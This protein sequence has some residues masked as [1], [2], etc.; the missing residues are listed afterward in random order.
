MSSS[1]E[2]FSI[3]L[4]ISHLADTS[5]KKVH[6]TRL[7]LC[8]V[9]LALFTDCSHSRCPAGHVPND[10]R[11]ACLAP[12]ECDGGTLSDSGTCVATQATTAHDGGAAGE[13]DGGGQ[14]PGPAGSGSGG[15]SGETAGRD[16]GDGAGGREGG[17][18]GNAGSDTSAPPAAPRCG[19]GKVDPDEACDGN[20]KSSCPPTVGCV[21]SKLEGAASTCDAECV[22]TMISTVQDGDGCCP[23]GA[24]SGTDKDCP[25]SC[26]D[27]DLAPDEKCEPGSTD[28]PCP[29]VKD[30]DDGDPCT[31]DIVTGTAEQCTALCVHMPITRAAANCDDG[32]PCTDDMM[33]ESST[34][35]TFECMHSIPRT[36]SGSCADTDPCTDDTP[37]KST[38]RCAYECPHRRQQPMAAACDDGN[39]CT[40]DTPEMNRT[41][42][43][44]ECPH[45]S[46]PDETPCMTTGTCSSGRCQFCGDGVVNRGEEC[47]PAATGWNSTTCSSAC[48]RTVYKRCN[49]NSQCSNG[50]SCWAGYCTTACTENT[51]PNGPGTEC[52]RIPNVP[53]PFCYTSKCVLPCEAVSDCPAGLDQ[54]DN[55]ATL[56]FSANGTTCS[57]TALGN[58]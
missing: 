42:C 33:V 50:Q 12:P 26:G 46:L 21:G 19:D 31:M 22:P 5:S 8:T 55:S 20:C 28:H 16:A 38:T 24:N 40:D 30:C 25:R 56:G 45:S 10:M 58:P 14:G 51:T 4:A 41:Q 13:N 43:A 34:A 53:Q 36:P 39:P 47:D 49:A 1:R 35:C 44:Y 52:P 6:M 57:S 23:M 7:A 15:S 29:T 3:E 9:A 54:C 18:A 11:Q 17:M 27:G 37:V 32:D 2:T 48:K